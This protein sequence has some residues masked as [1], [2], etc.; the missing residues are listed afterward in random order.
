MLV[1]KT[2]FGGGFR[3]RLQVK[4]LPGTPDIVLPKYKT[5]IFVNGCFW[6]AHPGCKRAKLPKTNRAF[7]KEKIRHNVE[8][9]KKAK[10][11]LDMMGWKVIT[12]WECETK[13][14][15]TLNQKL[16]SLI[17]DNI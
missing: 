1:R 6:H 4:S 14:I 9:D 8:R 11:E 15:D 12:V 17:K 5:I 16:N 13:D 2:L 3:Y 10:Q 7:W